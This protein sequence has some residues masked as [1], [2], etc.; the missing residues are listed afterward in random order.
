VAVRSDDLGTPK[1]LEDAVRKGGSARAA[2]REGEDDQVFLVPDMR[3]ARFEAVTAARVGLRQRRID[4][5]AGTT[6]EQYRDAL[7]NLG[8]IDT[9]TARADA[10]AEIRR[11]APQETDLVRQRSAALKA[12]DPPSAMAADLGRQR[13]ADRT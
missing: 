8:K 11:T 1:E 3:L 13:R 7:S 12:A 10:F 9:H 6:A 5:A 4:R 2:A